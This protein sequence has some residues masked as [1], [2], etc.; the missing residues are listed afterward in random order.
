[1]EIMHYL[2]TVGYSQLCKLLNPF[3]RF[4]WATLIIQVKLLKSE[5]RSA[6]K[7][8]LRMNN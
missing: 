3:A 8:Q 2:S 5:E 6:H 1:M 4:I 7:L